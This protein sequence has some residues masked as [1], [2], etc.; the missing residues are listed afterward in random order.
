METAH[1]EDAVSPPIEDRRSSSWPG[2]RPNHHLNFPMPTDILFRSNKAQFKAKP[3]FFPRNVPLWALGASTIKPLSLPLSSAPSSIHSHYA[4]T[5]TKPVTT[6][7]VVYSMLPSSGMGLNR[8]LLTPLVTILQS[9]YLARSAAKP[10]PPPLVISP[11]K[12]MS[13]RPLQ[14]S[15]TSPPTSTV[16]SMNCFVSSQISPTSDTVSSQPLLSPGKDFAKSP[17]QVA[18]PR[19]LAAIPLSEMTPHYLEL[20]T[21]AEEFKAKRIR[22]GYTQGAVGQSLANKGYSNFAQSTISR[23]EQMQLSATNAAAIKIVLEKWLQETECPDSTTSNVSELPAIAS[24]KRKKRAVFTPQTKSTLDEFFQQNPRPNRQAIELIAQQ[25]D[26]LP[27]EVRVWFCNKRQKYKQG[28]TSSSSLFLPAQSTTPGFSYHQSPSP[29][30]SPSSFTIEEMSKSSTNSSTSSSPIRLSS[31][32]LMSPPELVSTASLFP[33]LPRAA[34]VS[35]FNTLP[36]LI[37]QTR[38]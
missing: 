6:P 13:L 19:T 31:P 26:L 36:K 10:A 15:T 34:N 4:S 33:L 2:S 18:S 35:E 1:K 8:P 5:M 7:S 25:L 23:F 3:S 22:L 37:T 27:E 11:T 14:I 30:Q 9:G 29:K 20:K 38:A 28:S 17:G 21:F 24:R 16:P 32:F 12:P